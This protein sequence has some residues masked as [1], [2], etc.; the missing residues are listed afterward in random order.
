MNDS[1]L[2][3]GIWSAAAIMINAVG[4]RIYLNFPRTIIEGAGNAG[5]IQIIYASCLVLVI[6][7]ITCKLYYN[8]QGKDLIDLGEYL[9]GSFGRVI[10]GLPI[11]FIL[12]FIGSIILREFSENMKIISLPITPI[13][14]VMTFFC[15][16]MITGAY[17]GLEAIVRYHAIVVPIIAI[18]YLI[19]LLGASKYYDVSNFY[20]I[21]G[22]GAASILLK[23]GFLKISVYAPILYIFLMIP[24]LKTHKNFKTAGLLGIGICAF[25]LTLSAL[26]YIAA[27]PYNSGLEQF[28]PTFDLARLI[29]FGRFF[30]RIESIFLLSWASAGLMYLSVIL[31][32]TA[33]S[34][35]KT[36]KL[37]YHRPLILPFAIIQFCTSLLPPNLMTAIVMETKIYVK[38]TWIITL[39]LPLLILIL[40][41]AKKSYIEGA[42]NK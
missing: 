24:F 17:L 14:F 41:N 3:I 31:F 27:Y 23:N 29:D 42:K 2:V 12:M 32:F 13:N 35:K 37:E 28:L 18:A 4:A 5:W 33:Y 26:S 8:F 1:K 16:G 9:G 30:E 40:S 15:A 34:F 38:I 6:F 10:V 25:L 7:S 21:L 36:F 20:P 22:N 19:I 11:I 39:A